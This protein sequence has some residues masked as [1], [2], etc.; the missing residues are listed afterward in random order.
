ME[1]P[2]NFDT[3]VFINCALDE[4]YRPLLWS[5]VFS[6]IACGYQ[7]CLALQERDAGAI[8]L[9]K[10]K[11]LINSSRLG[12]HDISRTAPDTKSGLPRFNMPFEL[13]LDLGAREYGKAHLA[14]K[15]ILILDKERYRYQ[16]FLSDIAGQDIASHEDDPI[17]IIESVRSWLNA[18]RTPGPPLVGPIRIIQ[19]Y[20][21][22][23]AELPEICGVA[24]LN[25]T[26]LDLNDF[27]YFSGQWIELR[28]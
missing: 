7:P 17:Q 16:Q 23:Q 21:S 13:G 27:L 11:R 19:L 6:V 3:N 25:V 20:R 18:L 2:E 12:I 8:R 9:E 28:A 26:Y 22:F 24:A 4:A 10:I 15:Q 1:K 5:M 14:S